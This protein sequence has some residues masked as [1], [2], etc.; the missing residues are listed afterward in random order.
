MLEEDL[1]ADPVEQFKLW[2]EGA[3]GAGL[4]QPE[5]MALATCSAAGPAVRFVLL[6]AVDERGFTFFTNYESGKG[7]DLEETGRAALA[8]HWQPLGR[9]VRVTGPVERTGREESAAYFQSRPRGSQLA[10]AASA[11]SRPVAS[12]A[13]LEAAFARLESELGGGPVPA[14]EHWGGY[15]L[16]PEGIEFW[17]HRDNR[18]HDRLLYTRTPA[19]WGRQRLQP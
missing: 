16:R 5:A 1:L 13:E 9:Q 14:P 4:P 12:R 10:A 3:R 8:F 7:R 19:G 11:Q 18:L 6:K 15:R 17:E 2:F